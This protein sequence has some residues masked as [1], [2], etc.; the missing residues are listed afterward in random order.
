MVKANQALLR[1]RPWIA[2]IDDER[3]QGNAILVTLANCCYFANERGCGVRSYDTM[4]ALKTDT[5]R[6]NILHY[7]R[8]LSMYTVRVMMR[9]QILTEFGASAAHLRFELPTCEM[10]S[11]M[12]ELST[13]FFERLHKTGVT[14][15]DAV[16][17]MRTAFNHQPPVLLQS[18]HAEGASIYR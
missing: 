1:Q 13:P 18:G 5:R 7:S 2:H 3:N 16:K 12:N 11:K 8:P 9:E 17:L 15:A 6:A 4:A 10:Q 14:F